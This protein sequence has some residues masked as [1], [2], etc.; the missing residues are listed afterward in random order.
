MKTRDLSDSWTWENHLD[1]NLELQKSSKVLQSEFVINFISDCH[2]V[3]VTRLLQLSTRTIA[4]KK[5]SVVIIKS[6][7]AK[8]LFFISHLKC[9]ASQI[10][11]SFSV[12]YH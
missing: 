2:V 1:G 6:T 10:E 3:L 11:L 4:K 5:L 12:F 8:Y 7:S 9:M